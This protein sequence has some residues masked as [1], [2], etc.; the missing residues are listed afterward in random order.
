MS[1]SRWGLPPAK[2]DPKEGNRAIGL[3]QGGYSEGEFAANA[4]MRPLGPAGAQR[5]VLSPYPA[6]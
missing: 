2:I 4:L 6:M 3:D 1:C 5:D